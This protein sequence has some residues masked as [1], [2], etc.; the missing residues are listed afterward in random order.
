[1]RSSTIR[2]TSFLSLSSLC[3]VARGQNPVKLSS[4]DLE[5][6]LDHIVVASG[7][8]GTDFDAAAAELAKAAN[9]KIRLGGADIPILDVSVNYTRRVI[10]LDYRPGSFSVFANADIPKDELRVAFK[11]LSPV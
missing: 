8:S 11:N 3:F 7:S 5:L 10:Y 6:K 4:A 9:W 1:M 2:L